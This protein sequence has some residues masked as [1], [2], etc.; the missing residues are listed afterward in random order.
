[1]YSAEFQASLAAVEAARE[2][3]VTFE[4]KR[5]TAEEKDS[6]LRAYHPD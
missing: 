5:M 6:L 4:P 2:S 3:N 1:M